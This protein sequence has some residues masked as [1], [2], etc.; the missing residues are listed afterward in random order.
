MH[1]DGLCTAERGEL[2]TGIAIVG[3]KLKAL[4]GC[5]CMGMDPA[6]LRGEL[7]TGIAK[8]GGK[9]K[10]LQGCRCMGMDPAQLREVG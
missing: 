10:A 9:L 2:S 3:G 7:S 8:V 4:Q 5:R 6:Q 1:G